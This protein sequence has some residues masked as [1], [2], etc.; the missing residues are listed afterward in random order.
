VASQPIG[1][2]PDE[3]MTEQTQSHKIR[4]GTGPV[5]FELRSS[6]SDV[7]RHAQRAFGAWKPETDELLGTWT[8]S[9]NGDQIEIDPTPEPPDGLEEYRARHAA[10]AVAMVEYAAVA[11]IFEHCNDVLTFHAALLS[12]GGR[13]VALVGPSCAGKSTLATAL[14]NA[15]WQ[16]HCDD[17]TMV[18]ERSVWP[19][20]RRVGLRRESRALLGEPLWNRILSSDS[21]LPTDRGALFQPLELDSRSPGTME[22]AGIFFLSRLG[23]DQKDTAPT[24]LLPAHAAMA[25]LPYSNL[26]RRLSFSDALRPV[27][28]LMSR[29]PAWD[30]PRAPLEEMVQSV[31][32]LVLEH[33][34]N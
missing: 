9:R 1:I 31:N 7:V 16:F 29:V 2:V 4:W 19:A 15:G 23:Y 3:E 28:E 12:S 20:P 14:W 6:D 21:Y 32:R 26:I 8:V 25:I 13:A 30:L 24:R 18:R 17:L 10:H 34:S 11:R 5:A 33:D 27:G 22:L